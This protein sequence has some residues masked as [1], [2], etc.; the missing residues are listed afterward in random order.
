MG[1]GV[2]PSPLGEGPGGPGWRC[3]GRRGVCLSQRGGEEG[4]DGE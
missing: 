2:G 1:T 4:K 3:G